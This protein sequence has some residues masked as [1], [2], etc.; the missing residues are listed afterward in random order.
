M[1][2]SDLDPVLLCNDL[3]CRKD[4]SSSS[5]P[6]ISSSGHSSISVKDAVRIAQSNNFMGLICSSRLLVSCH[7]A[8][9]DPDCS[10]RDTENGTRSRR[11]YQSGWSRLGD[12]HVRR[13]DFIG[14][15]LGGKVVPHAG[16]CRWDLES[17]WDLEV[18]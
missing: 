1:L 13:S 16:R 18:Q 2:T 4:S 8:V 6:S 5:G 11:V 3:G 7:L 14:E 15:G 12:Q 17:E 9:I 10:L